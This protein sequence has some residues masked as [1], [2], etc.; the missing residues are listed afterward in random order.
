MTEDN[1]I[2]LRLTR[3]KPRAFLAQLSHSVLMQSVWRKPYI[4]SLQIWTIGLWTVGL[5]GGWKSGRL[6]FGLLDH[7][8]II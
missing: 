2:N 6:D 8:T 5:L 3:Y 4:P 7:L 1:I